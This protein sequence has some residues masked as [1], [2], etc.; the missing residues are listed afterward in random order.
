MSIF[1]TIHSNMDVKNKAKKTIF[2]YKESTTYFIR[3][4]PSTVSLLLYCSTFKC[5]ASAPS[6]VLKPPAHI[7]VVIHL[8]L[9]L[10]RTRQPTPARPRFVRVSS[11]LLGSS[12]KL[13][14]RNSYLVGLDNMSLQL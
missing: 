9:E 10:R 14:V 4:N 12:A 11:I 3:F 7:V 2:W 8:A 5:R 1:I 6:R 13:G